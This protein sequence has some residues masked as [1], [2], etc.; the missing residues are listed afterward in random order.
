MLTSSLEITKNQTIIL[1]K[2]KKHPLKKY[3]FF[4]KFSIIVKKLDLKS[5]LSNQI[6]HKIW[7]TQL[8]KADNNAN[9]YNIIIF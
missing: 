7:A 6:F 5:N 3:K 1:R 9:I 8:R 4:I 2:Y